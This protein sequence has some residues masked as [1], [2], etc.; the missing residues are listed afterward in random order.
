MRFT[1]VLL[2]GFLFLGISGVPARAQVGEEAPPSASLRRDPFIPIVLEDGS[3]YF[4]EE[5]IE[6]LPDVK[7]EDIHLEGIVGDPQGG[8]AFVLING[9]VLR[10]GDSVHGFILSKIR[11]ESVVLLTGRGE[12]VV[13]LVE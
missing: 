2:I 6:L 13:Q 11:S 8:N 7:L 5:S 12:V 9:E 10:E 4:E 3:F 1:Q